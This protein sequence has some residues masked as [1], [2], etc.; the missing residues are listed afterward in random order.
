MT[1][2]AR[3]EILARISE[4]LGRRGGG[5]YVSSSPKSATPGR[6]GTAGS[7]SGGAASASEGS[8]TAAKLTGAEARAAKKEV[9][10]IERRMDK[11]NSQIAKKHE[12]MAAHDQT[13]FEGLATLTAAIREYQDELDELEMRWLELSEQLEG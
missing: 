11:L 10:S 8:E 12:E 9:S 1:D 6:V 7:D 5:E 13:D 3:E 2:T 4:A